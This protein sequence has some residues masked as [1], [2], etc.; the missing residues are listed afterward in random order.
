MFGRLKGC[1]TKMHEFSSLERERLNN[2]DR[3]L[4]NPLLL[5]ESGNPAFIWL[6]DICAENLGAINS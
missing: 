3:L 4:K 1:M 5:I 2:V 6:T